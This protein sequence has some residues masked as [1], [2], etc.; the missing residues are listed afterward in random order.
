MDKCM[1]ANIIQY[2][3]INLALQLLIHVSSLTEV[4]ET[5]LLYLSA[6]TSQNI[7]Q[8]SVHEN[9]AKKGFLMF[10]LTK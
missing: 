6:Y 7:N 3:I 5:F 8:V 2:I 10:S 9:S 1:K 4:K